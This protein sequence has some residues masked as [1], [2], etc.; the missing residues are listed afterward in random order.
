MEHKSS[1]CG[2]DTEDAGGALAARLL[3]AMKRDR[4]AHARLIVVSSAS[5]AND[6]AEAAASR[7]GQAAAGR[8]HTLPSMHASCDVGA[9]GATAVIA[10]ALPLGSKPRV[11]DVLRMI[12]PDGCLVEKSR[13]AD[14]GAC[15]GAGSGS[16][17]RLRAFPA[18]HQLGADVVCGPPDSGQPGF[19]IVTSSHNRRGHSAGLLLACGAAPLV[20]CRFQRVSVEVSGASLEVE[21]YENGSASASVEVDSCASKSSARR[22]LLPLLPLLGFRPPQALGGLSGSLA[23]G[24][25]SGSL[26]LGGARRQGAGARVRLDRRPA[27]EPAFRSRRGRIASELPPPA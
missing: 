11:S 24:G 26:A 8:D 14:L 12:L 25:L 19:V 15:S 2:V 16:G 7:S 20:T 3:G 22:A 17:V 27:K 23:L 18:G 4:A 6:R 9:S 5:A 21:F 10:R 1:T 13:D